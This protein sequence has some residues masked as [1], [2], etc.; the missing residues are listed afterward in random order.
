MLIPRPECNAKGS[1]KA[2]VCCHCSFQIDVLIRFR[3]AANLSSQRLS[4]VLN[5]A[6]HLLRK[7]QGSPLSKMRQIQLRLVKTAEQACHCRPAKRDSVN[8]ASDQQP[9]PSSA[10]KSSSLV[11]GDVIRGEPVV[12][13]MTS[14]S[15]WQQ[16][17]WLLLLPWTTV[18]YRALTESFSPGGKVKQAV[19]VPRTAKCSRVH[20]VAGAL[21]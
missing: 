12:V 13:R 8:L 2:C 14:G 6:V 16:M 15:P 5:A 10:A 4:P 1:D 21:N 7:V 11:R 19:V 17:A 18:A 20:R 9:V 3:T